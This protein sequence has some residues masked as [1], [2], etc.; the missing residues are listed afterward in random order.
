MKIG[1]STAIII[2]L[3]AVIA[4]IIGYDALVTYRD[5]KENKKIIGNLNKTREEMEKEIKETRIKIRKI[6]TDPRAAEAILRQKFQMLKK[7]QFIV[8]D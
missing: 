4:S 6:Q 3:T 7:D 8:N 1:T 5:I 2:S